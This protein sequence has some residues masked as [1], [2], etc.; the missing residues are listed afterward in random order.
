MTDIQFWFLQLQRQLTDR[1]GEPILL[2][3]KMPFDEWFE[4]EIQTFTDRWGVA[5]NREVDKAIEAAVEM[6]L[7][8]DEVIAE[9]TART[10]PLEE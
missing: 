4:V 8:M 9:I 3:I 5:A 6:L 2:I 7:Q 10:A 1:V